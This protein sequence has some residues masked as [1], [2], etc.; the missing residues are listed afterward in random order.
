MDLNNL[1]QSELARLLERDR[2][3]IRAWTQQGL[4][5][6]TTGRTQRYSAPVVINWR[7]GRTYAKRQGITGLSPLETILL[8]HALGMAEAD[9]K[10]WPAYAARLGKAAGATDAEFREAFG[11][12]RGLFAR[13]DL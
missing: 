1:T 6:K 5:Y 10:N 2:T 11:F 7:V 3:T 12:V 9:P 8:G 13:D 4:P